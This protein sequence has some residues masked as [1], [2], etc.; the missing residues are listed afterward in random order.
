[1]LYSEQAV[2]ENLRNRDGKRVFFLG[3]G[4]QLTSGARDFLNRE[5]IPILPAE[6]AKPERFRPVSYTHLTLPTILRG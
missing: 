1:M 3:K 5:R 2:R 6:Q 4:D